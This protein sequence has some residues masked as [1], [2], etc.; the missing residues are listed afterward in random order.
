MHAL[1]EDLDEILFW[2]STCAKQLIKEGAGA[3]MART[4]WIAAVD[5]G[6]M[7]RIFAVPK[8]KE[9]KTVREQGMELAD[10]CAEFFAKKLIALKPIVPSLSAVADENLAQHLI[11]IP[12]IGEMPNSDN[13]INVAAQIKARMAVKDVSAV[14]E[15][16]P[17]EK[18]CLTPTAVKLDSAGR[19]ST[20]H[21][22]R[23]QKAAE[24]EVIHWSTWASHVEK[25]GQGSASLV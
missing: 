11:A 25:M 17:D 12:E 23:P 20:E 19:P 4:K 24:V 5:V 9:G 6:T 7:S 3:L 10:D 15:E 13:D 8:A 21:A 2:M 1:I 16:K 14:A 22:T 18:A